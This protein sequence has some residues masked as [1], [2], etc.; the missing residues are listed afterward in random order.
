MTPNSEHL[1]PH[2]AIGKAQGSKLPHNSSRESLATHPLLSSGPSEPISTG[3]TNDTS[4]ISS[5]PQTVYVP[6]VPRQQRPLPTSPSTAAKSTV[7]STPVSRQPSAPLNATSTSGASTTSAA[8]SKLQLQNLKAAAQKI[9]LNGTSLGWAIL[10]KLANEGEFEQAWTALTVGKATLLLPAED[11]HAGEKITADLVGDHVVFFDLASRACTPVV[12]LSG[13]R[14]ELKEYVIPQAIVTR[15]KTFT[16]LFL[17]SNRPS[18]LHAN[19]S[20]HC[21]HQVYAYPDF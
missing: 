9:G 15:L 13:L 6:Y 5:S 8:T 12:T 3:I 2:D 18:R 14:G 1:R 11:A 21:T 10:E 4:S 19:L 16:D 20:N 17:H 7:S